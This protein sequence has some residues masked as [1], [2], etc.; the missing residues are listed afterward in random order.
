MLADL[1]FCGLLGWAAVSDIRSHTIDNWTVL[2]ILILAVG[3]MVFNST[4]LVSRG[5]A[6][7]SAIPLV[8]L[9]SHG[10]LGGG[11]VKLIG[12][13]VCYIGLARLL[14]FWVLFMVGLIA[15]MIAAAIINKRVMPLAP[16]IAFAGVGALIVPYLL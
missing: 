12:A 8:L 11:D 14:P 15:L 6:F 1:I 16:A 9:W 7:L 5:L 3:K 10:K 13:T 2:G 4:E